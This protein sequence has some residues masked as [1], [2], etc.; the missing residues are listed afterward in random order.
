MTKTTKTITTHA[1]GKL[2]IAGEYAVVET[3]YPAILVAV[4]RYVTI[5]LD[6]S[7]KQGSIHSE[8]YGKQPVVWHRR[9]GK[10]YVEREDRPVDYVVSTIMTVEEL[11][12]E[13]KQPLRFFDLHIKSE[14]DDTSGR[15]F[16][17]GSSAAVTVATT[18]A[19]N[20]FYQLDLDALKMLKL[21]LLATVRVNSKASGGDLAASMFGG[22]ILYT[23][24][25]REW[26]IEQL[27]TSSIDEL[28]SK[29]WP[30]FSVNHIP[31]PQH[32]RLLVG[33]TGE[34]ASTTRLVDRL[35]QNTELDR[36]AYNNFLSS[37]KKATMDLAE[38]LRAD[39]SD[40]VMAGIRKSRQLLNT[41]SELA[42]L[43]IETAELARL[44]ETAELAGAAAKSSG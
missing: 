11:V 28:I 5:E 22:W 1:P 38:A 7:T 13:R 43:Q 16:G 9:D 20:T 25:D 44:C 14:L 21:S 15:K 12:A 8:Q 31:T 2:F 37:S 27:K 29:D 35:Q 33:W 10:L 36:N 26:L 17:L 30:G 18:R 39:D 32:T 34:P 6:E 3:G 23:S 19:L 42:G 24:P 4:N 40:A 41:L